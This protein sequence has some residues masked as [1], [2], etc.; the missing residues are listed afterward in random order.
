MT[1]P[2]AKPGITKA[3]E[4]FRRLL[5]KLEDACASAGVV[6]TRIMLYR[7]PDTQAHLYAKGRSIPGR[8]VT[9]APP[10]YSPHQFSLAADYMITDRAGH[11]Q[12]NRSVAVMTFVGFARQLGLVSGADFK[13]LLD[14]GHVEFAQWRSFVSW[15]REKKAHAT[16]GGKSR[17]A[18][19]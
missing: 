9:D 8:R 5:L 17:T 12:P 1:R 19:K 10:W 14:Y 13:S 11:P 15:P 18:V 2:K 4:D 6:A 3:Q 7:S 16:K